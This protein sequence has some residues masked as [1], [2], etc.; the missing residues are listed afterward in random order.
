MRITPLAVWCKDLSE[1][2]LIKAVIEDVSLSHGNKVVKDCAVC[3]CLAIQ[4]LLN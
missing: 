3:Y 2:D 1:E 4:T